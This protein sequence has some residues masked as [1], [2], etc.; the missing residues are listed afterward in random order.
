MHEFKGAL[1]KIQIEGREREGM[2]GVRE[3]VTF[4]IGGRDWRGI[5]VPF[6]RSLV[7]FSLSFIS[8]DFPPKF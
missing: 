1:H 7:F 4:Q 5:L 8:L 3:G 2:E 6:S